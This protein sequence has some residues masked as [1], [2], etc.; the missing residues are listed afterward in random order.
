MAFE[1]NYMETLAYLRHAYLMEHSNE[2][3]EA[4]RYWKNAGCKTGFSA[5][6]MAAAEKIA[7]KLGMP[8]QDTWGSREFQIQYRINEWDEL[9][10]AGIE[11]KPVKGYRLSILPI[12]LALGGTLPGKFVPKADLLQSKD[13]DAYDRYGIFRKYS[14]IMATDGENSAYIATR[15]FSYSVLFNIT[16]TCLAGCAGCYKGVVVRTEGKELEGRGL[17]EYSAIQH[18]LSNSTERMLFQAR[19]LVKWLDNHSEVS[20][21]VI[22]GGEPLMYGAKAIGEMLG[23][24]NKAA[25]LKN[26]RICTSSVFNGQFWLIDDAM[27]QEIAKAAKQFEANGKVLLMNT[28]ATN[29]AQLLAPENKEAA[30]RLLI[31]GV[32]GFWLQAPLQ[33]GVNFWRADIGR[34]QKEIASIGEASKTVPGAH[35]YKLIVDMNSPYNPEIT[36]PLEQ[37]SKV[38]AKM[39]EHDSIGDMNAFQAVN[40]L[41]PLGNAY[42]N[43]AAFDACW[44]KEVDRKGGKVTYCWGVK[45]GGKTT[46]I[47]YDEPLLEGIN[48]AE[49]AAVAPAEMREKLEKAKKLW[50][51][52]KSAVPMKKEAAF[53]RLLA[54]TTGVGIRNE[55]VLCSKEEMQKYYKVCRK[56]EKLI[57]ISTPGEQKHKLKG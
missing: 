42:L 45:A 23:I 25:H 19:Q 15:K 5:E 1:K 8:L 3:N 50:K 26:I 44:E 6:A 9:E 38:I 27:L 10:A 35:L 20:E 34:S 57:A 54:G 32:K 7:G 49:R 11:A 29:A 40:V 37:V 4:E 55:P 16:E 43:P 14:S 33:E 36:V 52:Y 12:N 56:A 46:I 21:I 41:T 24:L 48:D 18:E 28:H 53:G 47:P 13:A 31:A 51:D 30:R 39:N 2:N 22:S 17:H